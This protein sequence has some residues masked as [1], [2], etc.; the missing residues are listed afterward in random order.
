MDWKSTRRQWRM[1]MT[2]DVRS[3]KLS[4]SYCEYKSTKNDTAFFW[5]D[6]KGFS[7]IDRCPLNMILDSSSALRNSYNSFYR[8]L[9]RASHSYIFLLS[10]THVK[11]KGFK[12]WRANVQSNLEGRTFFSFSSRQLFCALA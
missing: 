4:N 7:G 12:G 2:S 8:P 9:S 5:D 11:R 1:R 6:S 3:H 10:S